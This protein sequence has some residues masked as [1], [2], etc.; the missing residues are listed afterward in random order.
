M[1]SAFESKE[2]TSTSRAAKP[3]TEDDDLDAFEKAFRRL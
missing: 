3:K 2:N 1:R